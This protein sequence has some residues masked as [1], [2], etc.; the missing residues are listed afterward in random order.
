MKTSFS[1]T[2]FSVF[3]AVNSIFYKTLELGWDDLCAQ[4]K[5]IFFEGFEFERAFNVQKTFEI[6]KFV[7]ANSKIIEKSVVRRLIGR[8]MLKLG[9]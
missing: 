6:E 1:L 2:P 7:P 5:N 8:V 3:S 9:L 4:N